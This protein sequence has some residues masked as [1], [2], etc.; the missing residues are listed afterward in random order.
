[1]AVLMVGTMIIVP[2][3][4]LFNPSPLHTATTDNNQKTGTFNSIVD[5]LMSL[6]PN[7]NYVRYVD[8]NASSTVNEWMTLNYKSNLPNVTMFGAKP[9]KDALASFPYP[10][11]GLSNV[12]NLQVVV[13]TD[14]GP[15]FDNASY[16]KTSI[17]GA[18]LRLVNS[19]Y[20]F[21]T[22]TYPTVSG[23]KEY[24]SIIDNFM[25][26]STA[27]DSAYATYADLFEQAN[28]SSVKTAQFA[29]VGIS[30]SLGFG[31]RYYAGV[32]P[33]ND[34]ICDYKVVIHLNQTLNATR[35]QDI[36]ERW[37]T[38][39]S[40][41][42]IDASTPQFKDSYVV[43]SAKGDIFNCLNDMVTSWEFARG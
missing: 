38:G 12:E 43:M 40:M 5:A 32:T 7:A 11:L 33:L 14:F 20:G 24:V 18:E 10:T 4:V 21:S 15:G 31:D 35:M 27:S 25:K 30:D 26:S 1:M 23:R 29:A 6:P 9:L 19:V 36:A 13:L 22:D 8:L 39:A 2:L 28:L 37:Q 34:T 16:Q 42:G 41:Y 17:N 3:A